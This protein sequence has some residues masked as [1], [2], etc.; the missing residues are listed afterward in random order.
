MTLGSNADLC[1]ERSESERAPGYAST[2]NNGD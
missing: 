2:A 1:G